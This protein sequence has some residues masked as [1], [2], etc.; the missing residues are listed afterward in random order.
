M[1]ADNW[2]LQN[3]EKE[4]IKKEYKCFVGNNN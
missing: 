1:L 2:E 3:F 4:L